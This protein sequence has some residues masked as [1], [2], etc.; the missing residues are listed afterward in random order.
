MNAIPVEL[1]VL[2]ERPVARADQKAETDVVIEIRCKPT[3]G[4][5]VAP[6]PL[7]LCVVIDRSGSMQG[8]KL[9]MAKR[10]CLDIFKQL[11]EDDLFTVV[12]FDNEAKV[13]VNPQVPRAE[14]PG[15]I[16]QISSGGQTN[17][18][19]GWYLGV[20][21][22]QTHTTREYNNRLFLLSDGQANQGETKRAVL[23][24][25]AAQS[26]ELGI[27]TSTIGI[28]EDF[29]EDLL[30]AMATES[31]GRFWYVQESKIEDIIEAEFQ[32]AL[33]VTV[34]RPR[35]E[36][37]LSSG[38]TVSRELNTL[39]RV[40]GKYR[41]RPLKGEDVFNFAIRLESAPSRSAPTGSPSGRSCTTGRGS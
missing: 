7:N 27:T 29:Q 9:E 5:P 15:K 32:G 16:E 1:L 33:T 28:G 14:I 3:A 11:R 8:P 24:G 10:S 30:E 19:L 40:A 25:E 31:G 4:P 23:A 35:V 36:L 13:V 41:V 21:E 39:T 18:S 17:L 37:R 38:V 34:D 12:T 22:L 20:L 26:R 6:K 2:P